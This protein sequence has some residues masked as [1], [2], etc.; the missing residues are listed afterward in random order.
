MNPSSSPFD[1]VAKSYDDV[2]TL[3]QTG[4]LQRNRVWKYLTSLHFPENKASVLEIN[5]GTGEDACWFATRGHRVLATDLSAE[6][7]S[8]AEEKIKTRGLKDVR[9][10][11][12]DMRELYEKLQG[13]KFDLVF[14]DFGGMNCLD[15][16]DIRKLSMEI[17]YLLKPGGS[18][19][20]VLMSRNCLW[21]RFYFLLKRNFTAAFRRRSKSGIPVSLGQTIQ[22]T[23]Y[24]S[25]DQFASLTGSGWKTN[26]LIPIGLFLPPSYLDPFF[27]KHPVLLR[28]L[29]RAE[30]L[31]GGMSWCAD[32]A[33]HYLLHFS[34]H[35]PTLP[36]R[37]QEIKS[38]T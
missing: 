9:F 30:R 24:Y 20:A 33:D 25:P 22:T 29:E 28:F 1:P 32:Y 16:N 35:D 27:S 14:S 11:A 15:E 23:Y 13:Q 21:E 38:V 10:L 7:I 8:Q 4:Q 17:R 31:F 18:F 12:C 6:M 26:R 34:T 19:I 37:V 36:T 5:C 3:T 2:F